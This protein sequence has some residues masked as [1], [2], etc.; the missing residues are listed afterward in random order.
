MAKTLMLAEM[1]NQKYSNDYNV[2]VHCFNETMITKLKDLID[3]INTSSEPVIVDISDSRFIEQ[4][5]RI[6]V[7]KLYACDNITFV[8]TKRAY[9]NTMLQQ[10]YNSKVT[11]FSEYTEVLRLPNLSSIET[12]LKH[13]ASLDASKKYTVRG[14]IP[15]N[16]RRVYIDYLILLQ[17]CRPDIAVSTENLMQ[18]IIMILHHYLRTS[19]YSTTQIYKSCTAWIIKTKLSYAE[20]SADSNGTYDVGSVAHVTKEEL[21][22]K[23]YA[24]PATFGKK[25]LVQELSDYVLEP[26]INSFVE[27]TSHTAKKRKTIYDVLKGG[28]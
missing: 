5:A 2:K 23:W 18:D 6:I 7:E 17:L 16:G 20:V 24:I 4:T 9:M 13:I 19:K 26:I 28:V 10:N 15:S 14:G 27:Y 3:E 12:V 8:D 22:D 1:F 11:D 21:W 25:V